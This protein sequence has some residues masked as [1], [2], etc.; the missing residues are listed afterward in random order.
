MA[1][2][3]LH[4]H[5]Y[6]CKELMIH[7][8]GLQLPQTLCPPR[9]QSFYHLQVRSELIPGQTCRVSTRHRALLVQF[10]E[11]PR[12]TSNI[13]SFIIYWWQSSW[14]LKTQ[15]QRASH[16]CFSGLGKRRGC[17]TAVW[18]SATGL[19]QYREL[20]WAFM[21]AEGRGKQSWHPYFALSCFFISAHP[22]L[23]LALPSIP[24][25]K[26]AEVSL[27]HKNFPK[28][29]PSTSITLNM[30]ST[31]SCQGRKLKTKKPPVL[32]MWITNETVHRCA[33]KIMGWPHFSC[34]AISCILFICIIF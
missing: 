26:S 1:F 10:C 3:M 6:F 5:T 32:L 14:T 4:M 27:T 21:W 13:S 16:I 2:A 20:S 9:L 12:H 34:G 30:H 7:F 8:S 11:V 29:S 15:W 24:M 18:D 17:S 19:I 22:H 23:T 28:N 25:Y 31:E 33:R